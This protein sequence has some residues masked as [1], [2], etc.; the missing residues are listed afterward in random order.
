MIQPIIRFDEL[1]VLFFFWLGG[2]Y[3]Q[4]FPIIWGEIRGFEATESS[5]LFIGV[6]IGTNLGVL[7]NLYLQRPLKTLVPQWHG[8]PPCEIHLKGAMLAGPFLVIG[9]FWL[10]WT[11]AYESIP[12]W[13]PALSTIF[14][15]AS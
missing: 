11:G 3:H 14:I 1:R 2:C 9:I 12:W 4:A 13:I 7:M 5:L 15:G 8:N 6:G 10:G